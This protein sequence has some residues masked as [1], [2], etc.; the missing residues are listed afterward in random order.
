LHSVAGDPIVDRTSS[1][2]DLPWAESLFLLSV[3]C[4]HV[5]RVAAGFAAH[6]HL[7]LQYSAWLRGR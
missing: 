2:I 1:T 6:N 3:F 7:A 5:W 4:C